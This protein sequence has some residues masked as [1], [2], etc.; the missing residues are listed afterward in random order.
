MREERLGLRRWPRRAGGTPRA[1]RPAARGSPR[2]RAPARSARP[3]TTTSTRGARAPRRCGRRPRRGG[4]PRTARRPSA[5]AR[6]RRSA[7]RC[8]RTASDGRRRRGASARSSALPSVFRR[9]SRSY[10]PA[11]SRFSTRLDGL[12]ALRPAVHGDER[13]FFVET[14]RADTWG[15]GRADRL[16]PGQPLALAPRDRARHPL[17]DRAGPGQARALAR[18]RCW[19]WSSTCGAGS[20]TYGQW[21]AIE[22]DDDRAPAAVD[23]GRLRARLLRAVGHRRLRL[24]VH[25]LLRPGDRVGHLASRTPTSASSG[26]CRASCSSPSATATRRGSRTSPT[27]AVLKGRYAPSPTG[28]LHLGNLR[29]ALLAWLF[30]RSAGSEF[31]MRIEDLDT[32]RVRERFVEQQLADLAAIGAR[33]GRRRSCASPSASALYE[34][35]SPARAATHLPVLLH[36][37]ARSARRPR[38]RT[39]PLPRAPTPARAAS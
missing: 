24:Q 13:G 22:L 34:D 14:F 30:A 27:R 18:G 11:P 4:R 37:G 33:L 32:G 3:S 5:T 15:T 8:T 21:E 7:T 16:R 1:P 19:T 10:P 28:V 23:P 2:S 20:P 26:R 9:R 17:P 31:L 25:Q 36:A 6:T 38:R 35:A 29:T 39:A 12:V